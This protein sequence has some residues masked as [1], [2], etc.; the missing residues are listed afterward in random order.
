MNEELHRPFGGSQ[1]TATEPASNCSKGIILPITTKTGGNARSSSAPASTSF[2]ELTQA[3]LS[4]FG[5]GS[6]TTAARKALI[7]PRS[8][9]KA[10]SSRPS[11]C[12]RLTPLLISRGLVR[13]ITPMSMRER[14]DL[15]TPD[16]AFLQPDGG[17][18]E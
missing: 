8:E 15:R 16:F 11:L 4:L 13:G 1:K 2:C 7:A 9:T 17:P 10:Q 18:A 5:G 14:S 12:D 6:S 3:T